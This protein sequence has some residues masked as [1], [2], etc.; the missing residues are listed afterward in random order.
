MMGC[1]ILSQRNTQGVIRCESLA[2]ATTMLRSKERF[3][4]R[5]EYIF[6]VWGMFVFC[7]NLLYGV[8]Y[9]KKLFVN[10]NK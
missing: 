10:C 1:G 2:G 5:N 9:F 8:N 3:S 4:A 7:S 6:I